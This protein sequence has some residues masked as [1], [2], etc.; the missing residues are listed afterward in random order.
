MPMIWLDLKEAG[1]FHFQSAVKKV[2]TPSLRI[3]V[4]CPRVTPPARLSFPGFRHWS[5]QA[6]SFRMAL[7]SRARTSSPTGTASLRELSSRH[8]HFYR[9]S[10]LPCCDTPGPS[11]AP[12]GSDGGPG[13]AESML[14][15]SLGGLP[16]HDR[17]RKECVFKTG[18]PVAH[19][20]VWF[21]DCV[22]ECVPVCIWSV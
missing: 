18:A 1:D 8:L 16:V 15:P 19:R 14:G 9:C 11:S 5:G 3:S 10:A 13:C 12:V 20:H 4:V 21:Q 7:P 22:I 17:T 2:S 6:F